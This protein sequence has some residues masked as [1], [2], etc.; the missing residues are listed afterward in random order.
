MSSSI[1]HQ[2]F[3]SKI[4]WLSQDPSPLAKTIFSSSLPLLFL[5]FLS[6]LYAALALDSVT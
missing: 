4:K 5:S 6:L 1:R 2:T 3:P